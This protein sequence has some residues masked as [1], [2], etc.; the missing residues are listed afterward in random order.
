[1]KGKRPGPLHLEPT[2]LSGHTLYSVRQP[3]GFWVATALVHAAARRRFI[4]TEY[5]VP[6]EAV[7]FLQ[8]RTCPPGPSAT[9]HLSHLL[10]SFLSIASVFVSAYLCACVRSLP[11]CCL[12][13]TQLRDMACLCVHSTLSLPPPGVLP[14][15]P[16]VSSTG[17]IYWG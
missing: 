17:D 5:S 16:R 10:L 6:L 12:L 2:A 11:R 4:G 14:S 1:M 3:V 8:L 9:C 7:G 13:L 15:A